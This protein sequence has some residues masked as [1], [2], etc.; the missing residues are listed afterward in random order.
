[1][2]QAERKKLRNL[3][4]RH[5]GSIAQIGRDLGIRTQ[6][7]SEWL[8]GKVVSARIEARVLETAAELRAKEEQE[9]KG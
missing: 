8:S 9:K 3:L 2:T 6:T 4:R 5:R 1:M 7:I